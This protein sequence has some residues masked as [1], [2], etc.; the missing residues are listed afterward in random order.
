M[1]SPSQPVTNGTSQPAYRP[2]SDLSGEAWAGTI[3]GREVTLRFG[4]TNYAGDVS[5]SDPG[6]GQEG[7]WHGRG[8]LYVDIE[9]AGPQRTI[10]GT[11]SPDGETMAVTVTIPGSKGDPR[12]VGSTEVAI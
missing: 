6:F 10:M 7:R 11:M 4:G 9:L 5:V 3:D 12:R 1:P 8:R 2:P